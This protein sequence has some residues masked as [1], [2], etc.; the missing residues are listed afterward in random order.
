[1]KRFLAIAKTLILATLATTFVL[2]VA[3]GFTVWRESTMRNLEQ[4]DAIVVLGAAQYAG[5]PS[6]VLKNRLDTAAQVQQSGYADVIVTVGSNL[7]GDTTTE[8]EAGREYLMRKYASNSANVIAIAEGEDT[9][10]SIRAVHKVAQEKS[11]S[12]LIFVSDS[13]H[14]ARIKTIA[15]SFGYETFTTSAVSGP[16][17]SFDISYFAK[18]SAGVVYFWVSRLRGSL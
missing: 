14:S 6:P 18:E 13:L 16:G 10:T 5:K 7:P 11:W 4:A 2:S 3:A 8:A 1:M 12:T 9:Y 15:E 17:S